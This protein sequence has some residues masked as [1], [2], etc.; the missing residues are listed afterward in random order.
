MQRLKRD[1]FTFNVCSKCNRLK[2][3]TENFVLILILE[4]KYNFRNIMNGENH[5]FPQ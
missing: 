1:I 4:Y 5:K 3:I 2:E